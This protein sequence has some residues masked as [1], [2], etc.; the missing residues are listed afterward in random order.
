MSIPSFISSLFDSS[1]GDSSESNS[2]GPSTDAHTFDWQDS[3][4]TSQPFQ[5]VAESSS[6]FHSSDFTTSTF[7]SGFSND[8]FG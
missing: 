7:G 6:A 4:G 2:A 3:W 1:V 5:S 8:P